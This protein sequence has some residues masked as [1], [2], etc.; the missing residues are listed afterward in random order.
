[1]RSNGVVAAL[2]THDTPT[3]FNWLVL[4]LSF[5]GIADRVAFGYIRDHG[6]AQWSDIE[7]ALARSPTCSKLGGHWR[8]DS[9][10]YHKGSATCSE[11]EQFDACPLPRHD[12][13][14]GSLN[15]M[16]YSLFFF[17]RD[18]AD[19]DPVSWIDQQL[20]AGNDVA[21]PNRLALLRD[22]LVEPLRHVHG[23]SDKVLAL[24]LSH[25]LMAGGKRRSLWFEVGASFIAVDTLIHNFLHRTGILQ[26]FGAEHP[27]GPSCYR[28]GSC[29]DIL[30]QIAPF[31]DASA[32]D[33]A[34]PKI[35]PRFVQFALWRYCAGSGLNICNGNR[36]NDLGR[37][38][39]QH[40]RLRSRCDRVVLHAPPAKNA[41]IAA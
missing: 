24:A 15:Q 2:Q 9:C 39:N 14:N 32:F 17:I 5:Q 38:D 26:R 34:F 13:R 25:L 37:C 29:C 8:F 3:I 19:G 27:Y 21:A 41:E 23:V 6:N 16:A 18:V 20:A 30:D 11:P 4:V 36:I 12:L 7:L 35:F 22:A 33:P 40:C 28:S 31:I 10:G 1:M